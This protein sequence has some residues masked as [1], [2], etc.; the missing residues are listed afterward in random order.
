MSSGAAGSSSSKPSHPKESHMKNTSLPVRVLQLA[1]ACTLAAAGLAQGG[2]CPSGHLAANAL[3]AAPTAPVGVTDTELASIDLAQENVHLEQRR[4]RLRHM[5][6]APGGVV[7]LHSHEDRPAL[8]RVDSGEIYENNSKC[9]VPIL[10][11]AGDVAREHLGT[12]HWWKNA[13][14]QPVELTI[15]DIVNDAKPATMAKQVM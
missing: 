4:L 12:K 15:A 14:S 9:A 5:T 2:E 11:K 13:G 3:P 7:P 1:V 10:H 8:I 6:I